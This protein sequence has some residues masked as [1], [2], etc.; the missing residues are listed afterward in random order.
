[1]IPRACKGL[2]DI[3][4]VRAGD[5]V[6]WE[7][8]KNP[9]AMIT[10]D[11]YLKA[12]GNGVDLKEKDIVFVKEG[13]YRIGDVAMLSKQDIRILLNSHCLVFRINDDNNE[14]GI[15]AFYLL[16]LFSHP[17]VK[18]QLYNKVM[19]DTTLPNIGDR[20]KELKLPIHKDPTEKTKLKNRVKKAFSQHWTNK[21]EFTRIQEF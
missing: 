5:V 21:R 14:Y 2:G 20:W 11:V 3:P 7:I 16:Y 8:Y 9:T 6:D 18:Q 12:K 4:Y 1:M 15:D 13:S 19:V 10:E 17:L